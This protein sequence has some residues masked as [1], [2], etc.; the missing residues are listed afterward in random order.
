VWIATFTVLIAAARWFSGERV[1]CSA[2]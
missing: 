1:D 2:A